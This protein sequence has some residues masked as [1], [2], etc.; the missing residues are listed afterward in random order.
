MAGTRILPPLVSTHSGYAGAVAVADDDS[1]GF[2]DRERDHVRARWLADFDWVRHPAPS[3]R[4]RLAVPLGT[5]RVGLLTTAGAHP[6][7]DRPIGA[8]GRAITVGL[9]EALTLTH[10]GYDAERAAR[11]LDT[12]Y[13]VRSLLALA[14][15]G[16]IGALAPRVCSTMGGTLIGSRVVERGVPAAVEWAR[17][18]ALDLAL[19]VPA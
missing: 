6:A 2:A 16:E 8:S 11:D 18:Q 3:P 12:V 7:G 10:S 1:V 17:D 13:P 15:A 9:G 5:A 19:L 14:A 4:I